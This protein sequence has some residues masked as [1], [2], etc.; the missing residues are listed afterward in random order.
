[1]AYRKSANSRGH[2]KSFSRNAMKV[3]KKNI[4]SGPMRGGIRL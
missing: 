3:H 4:S 1:M 2:K